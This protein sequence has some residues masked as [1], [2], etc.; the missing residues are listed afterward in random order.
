MKIGLIGVGSIGSTLAKRL[1]TKGHD[2]KVA[3]SRG[4][5]TL[6]K[7]LLSTG[8]Q[9][10]T[11]EEAAADVDALILSIPLNAMPNLAPL[12][13]ALPAETAVIDTSN[14]YPRRDD[15][16]DAI[17]NGQV[18]SEWVVE[19]L[20]RS[21][22]KAWNAI[23]AQVLEEDPREPGDPQRLAIP[24]AADDAR[25]KDIAFT[26]VNDSGLDPVDA[27]SLADSWRQQPG[28]PVYGTR[29]AAAEI[30]G[31]LEA[32]QRDRLP[33]RRDL[34]FDIVMD[35]LDDPTLTIDAAFMTRLARALYL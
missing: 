25:A 30:P 32:A 28:A 26:L 17:E 22:V 8:A 27:G 33:R 18:E 13:Q 24:V 10:V 2:V 20:G 14:Y 34:T 23:G 16:I 11:A 3:N 19:Q 1:P 12:I 7:D 6:D 9:A 31:A 35:R 21:I 4:P 15:T 5:E 29:L